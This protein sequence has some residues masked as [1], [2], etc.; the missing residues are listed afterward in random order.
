MDT[1]RNKRGLRENE[2]ANYC[3]L[4]APLLRLGRRGKTKTSTPPFVKIGR[5]VIYLQDDLDVWLE[6]QRDLTMDLEV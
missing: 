5:R 4:S 2:A 3:G 6:Q 1:L